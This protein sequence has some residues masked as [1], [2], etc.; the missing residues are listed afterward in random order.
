MIILLHRIVEGD[1]GSGE[2]LVCPGLPLLTKPTPTYSNATIAGKSA[3][4]SHE[5]LC[6]HNQAPV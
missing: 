4:H 2:C 6:Q 1:Y 5:L 3:S